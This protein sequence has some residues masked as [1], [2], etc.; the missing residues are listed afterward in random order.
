MA[1]V[2]A[3]NYTACAKSIL[4]S[5]RAFACTP[6]FCSR[7]MRVLGT[8]YPTLSVSAVAPPASPRAQAVSAALNEKAAS[9]EGVQQWPYRSVAQAL[10]VIPRTLIQNCG[11]N[12]IRTLTKLRVCVGFLLLCARGTKMRRSGHPSLE[13]LLLAQETCG[14]VCF[15]PVP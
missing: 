6:A 9:V 14:S 3:A 15:C 13:H 1:C 7:Y 5:L 2:Q 8:P 4:F 11:A 10:E 12:V